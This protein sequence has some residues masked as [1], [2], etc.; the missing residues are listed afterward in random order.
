[1]EAE[2]LM[3]HMP[4]Y[5]RV[6]AEIIVLQKTIQGELEELDFKSQDILNQFFIYTATWSLPIWERIFGLPVGDETSNIEERREKLISKLRSYGTTTKEMIVRVG[7][8]FTNGGVQI[9]EHNEKYSFEVVFTNVIGVPK[10]MEDFKKTIELIKPAHL[11]YE[12][13]FKY[14]THK[15]LRQFTHGELKRYKHS[16]LYNRS[17]ILGGGW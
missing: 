5:Y 1:M 15:L 3:R 12:I 17:D 16:E 2:K 7:N 9:I 13:V 6:I 10:N 8:A 11:A 4:K 14:R